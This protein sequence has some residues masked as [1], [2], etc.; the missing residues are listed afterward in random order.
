M[1]EVKADFTVDLNSGKII[2]SNYVYQGEPIIKIFKPFRVTE[3]T[4]TVV[5][6]PGGSY[7]DIAPH[8]ADC[9][10]G[11]LANN[12]IIGVVLYYTVGQ[13]IFPKPVEDVYKAIDWIRNSGE[14]NKDKI[15]I[16]GFSAGGHLAS[17][18]AAKPDWKSF[19]IHLDFDT[20]FI[21]EF[22]ILAYPVIS[23]QKYVH[24]GTITNLLGINPD[25]ELKKLLSSELNIT[26]ASPP[27]FIFHTVSDKSV[28]V[29]HSI[30][31]ARNC[32][33]HSVPTE[34]HL[35]PKGD[36]GVGLAEN[37]RILCRWPILMLDW[38]KTI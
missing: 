17:M 20:S 3:N 13:A 14:V 24:E 30:M 10:G 8:E 35:Y 32:I 28:N 23:F 21:A 19:N 33:S 31:F 7:G 16:M 22:L 5:I 29:N 9:V 36:H 11:F 38:L 27:T 18:I 15:G 4:R 26:E 12:S 1:K 34:L 25:N 2:G 37:D 6:C